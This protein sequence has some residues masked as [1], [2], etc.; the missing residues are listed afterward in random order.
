LKGHFEAEKEGKRERRGKGKEEKGREGREKTITNKFLATA[1]RVIAQGRATIR[2]A[3]I[4][5]CNT[6]ITL[7]VELDG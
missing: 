2:L 4:T 3:I 5:L 7:L 1:L 6:N